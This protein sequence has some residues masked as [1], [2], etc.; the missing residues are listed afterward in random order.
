MIAAILAISLLNS[1]AWWAR[2]TPQL[3]LVPVIVLGALRVAQE[4]RLRL[5]GNLLALL[6]FANIFLVSGA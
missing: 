4:K 6:L 5:A 1:K 2:Y 3:W